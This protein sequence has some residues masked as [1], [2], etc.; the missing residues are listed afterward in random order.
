[1]VRQAAAPRPPS[2]Q[3]CAARLNF[4]EFD[5]VP[6][7]SFTDESG[8]ERAL[9]ALGSALWLSALAIGVSWYGLRS[10]LNWAL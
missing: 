4:L 8:A 6:S 1:V 10:R 3:G 5:H 7:F 9:S 2:C